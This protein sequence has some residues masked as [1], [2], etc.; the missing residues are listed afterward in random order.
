VFV[1]FNPDDRR[2][3]RPAVTYREVRAGHDIRWTVITDGEVRIG[4]G[5]QS[6]VGREESI[7]AVC[8]QA[9]GSARQIH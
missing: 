7:A 5:C 6:A 9:I 3:G 2:S 1:D 8:E 4:I